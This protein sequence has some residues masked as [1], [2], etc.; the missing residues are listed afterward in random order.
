[1][2]SE[3]VLREKKK[4]EKL[5]S[6]KI[7]VNF[8]LLAVSVACFLKTKFILIPYEIHR[9]AFLMAINLVYSKITLI[10]WK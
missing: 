1:M 9:V 6:V 7:E 2:L 8:V 4:K 10:L 3:I 5:K